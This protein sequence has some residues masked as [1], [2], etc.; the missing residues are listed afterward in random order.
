MAYKS[1]IEGGYGSDASVFH[2]DASH[3]DRIDISDPEL[4]FR[5]HFG[6]SGPDLVLTGQDGHRHIVPG[7]FGTEKHPDLVAPN[8]AH[9]SGDLV[10]LLAGS[11]TPGHYAQANG[12][13]LPPDA[14]GKVQKVVGNVTVL[15]NGTAVTLHVGDAV[16]KSDVIET[17][18]NSSCGIAFPDGTALDVVA[19]T[20]MAL[21]DYT[22]DVAGAPNNALFTLVEGTFAFVAGQVAH[23]GDGMKITTPV[24]TMGIRGTVGL[25]KSEPTVVNSKLGH[26]WSVVL[27]ED[28][29]GSHHLGR[30]AIIDQDPTSATF[31][32]VIYLLDSSEYIAYL[33]PQG[34]GLP[35]HVR[36][37]PITSSRQ[38]DDR[39][40]YD[41]LNQ[42]ISAYNG[43]NPRS[44]PNGGSGDN[45]NL[46][47]PQQPNQE[48]GGQPLPINFQPNSSGEGPNTTLESFS[49]P[50]QGGILPNS[51][52]TTPS[53]LSTIFIWNSSGPSDWPTDPNWNTG[54]APDSPIDQVIIQSGTVN[55]D[56]PGNTAVSALTV[57]PGAILDVTSGQLT[58]GNLVDDGTIVVEGDPPTLVIAGPATIGSTHSIEAVGTGSTVDFEDSTVDNQ[59][60][61]AARQGG[62]VD[63]NEEAI[64][65]ESGAQIEARDFHSLVDF[66]DANLDNFGAITAKHGG[67]VLFEGG[68]IFNEAAAADQ[69]E[70]KIVARGRGSEIDLISVDL[71][72]GGLVGAMH[73]GS[74]KF[75]N[76][77]VTNESGA[78]IEAKDGIVTFEHGRVANEFG[79]VIVASEHGRID[80]DGSTVDNGN[81]GTDAGADLA[82]EPNSGGMIEAIGC[83]SIIR[84]CDDARVFNAGTIL[85]KDGG[86]ISFDDATVHNLNS[87]KIDATRHGTIELKNSIVGNSGT[88]EAVGLCSAIIFSYGLL[89]NAGA[90]LAKDGG[91]VDV[92]AS[93][94]INDGSLA[95]IRAEA[96]GTLV[97]CDDGVVNQHGAMIVAADFGTVKFDA[98]KVTNDHCSTIAA[99]KGGLVDIAYSD[100]TNTHNSF[101]EA[102]DGGT[103][104]FNHAWVT[105][106]G[107]S[108]MEAKGHHSTVDLEHTVVMND[109][110]TIAAIGCDARVELIDATIVGGTLESRDGAI[111]ENVGGTSTL[112]GITIADGT[113]IQ[114]NHG[115]DVDLKETITVDGTITFQ[116]CGTFTL[117]GPGAKIIGDTG[118]LDNLGTIDGAGTIGSCDGALWLINDGIIDANIC[119]Q[120]LAIHTGET[121]TNL[122]TLEAANGGRLLV[123][124]PVTGGGT[125]LVKGGTID[126]AA[127]ADISQITFNNGS[128]TAYGEVIF[129]DPNGLD[130]TVNDFAGTRSNLAH[131]D[132]IE[133]TGTWTVESET[134]CG[135]NVTLELKNGC[136]TA[137]F[138]FDDFNGQLQICTVNGNTLITDPAVSTASSHPAVS[139][140]G[141]GNDT[142]LFHP[143][144]GAE[145]INNF[146]PQANTIELDHFANVQSAQALAAAVTIDAHSDAVLEL[147][148]GDSVAIPGMTASFLQAH[149]QSL[150]HLH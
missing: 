57:D 68:S 36:V 33:E 106:T 102:T 38:F 26:V 50:V 7:Y 133:L 86:L 34:S 115:T 12:P 89:G 145:T 103:V 67:S 131:S 140:G 64:T 112:D 65:N 13:T 66:I 37:E 144:E 52:P 82:V 122:G 80:F 132:G 135:G 79:A 104:I 141:P 87:G 27:H 69:P 121:M 142:F 2:V 44:G 35:P 81:I 49:V 136:E 19:G 8:G 54:S 109:G 97:F 47:L 85:G 78:T 74:M 94:V 99:T 21:N 22:Y 59:G 139:I 138:N 24:A 137:A 146:N 95:E 4:M 11:P 63:L 127:A 14:I 72:N 75:E 56:L 118:T 150:V 108:T 129:N 28:L 83:G 114:A 128:G 124:D 107:D 30:I 17:A 62:T 92:F 51:T 53:P 73:Y 18:A 58:A 39:H 23:S 125:A 16:H 126:F 3:A 148:H 61:I 43:A 111:I 88:I 123:D 55:Y 76:V 32:Q 9:L 84:F 29:D 70:A 48:N 46:L 71:I 31:G 98:D 90:V 1:S 6:R 15:R 20:R 40:F 113:V 41:D 96:C 149:L 116:G 91:S 101:I 105:N 147:G 5:G 93:K 120:T 42:I 60:I 119:G 110:G 77:A 10:D 130:V 25:F 45:P 117:D 100:V 134:V 143:G